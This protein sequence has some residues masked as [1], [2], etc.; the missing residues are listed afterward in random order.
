MNQARVFLKDERLPY[1]IKR[2]IV[3][4]LLRSVSVEIPEHLILNSN[5]NVVEIMHEVSSKFVFILDSF[6]AGREYTETTFI[7]RTK[8][9]LTWLDH[10]RE[11]FFPSLLIKKWPINYRTII[12]RQKAVITKICPHIEVPNNDKKHINFIIS[13][14]NT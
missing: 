10:V 6:L 8:I 9:P 2:Y 14:G 4:K 3:D 13:G 5:I 1:E 11:R 7:D 12:T